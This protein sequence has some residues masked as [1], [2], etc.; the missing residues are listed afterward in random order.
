MIARFCASKGPSMKS[1]EKDF[2]RSTP[3]ATSKAGL[4]S[5]PQA[6]P[7]FP[8]ST[9]QIN[10][11]GEY[12]RDGY[13][14]SPADSHGSMPSDVGLEDERNYG[15]GYPAG[16]SDLG[17]SSES[18]SAS[19]SPEQNLLRHDNDLASRGFSSDG[20]FSPPIRQDSDAASEERRLGLGLDV[21]PGQQLEAAIDSLIGESKEEETRRN[22][23]REQE[24]DSE[25]D[26]EP[27]QAPISSPDLVEETSSTETHQPVFLTRY[28]TLD[29]PPEQTLLSRNDPPSPTRSFGSARSSGSGSSSGS[30]VTPSSQRNSWID[31]QQSFSTSRGRSNLPSNP[32]WWQAQTDSTELQRSISNDMSEHLEDVST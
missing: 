15:F 3:I 9:F 2:Q 24:Q 12:Q 4:H 23:D 13:G 8:P 14:V 22:Q 31:P 25:I 16:R 11:S 27:S 28:E 18:A 32:L 26:D 5:P 29:A 30:R 10:T 1:R 6:A 19:M 17:Y 20:S 7:D 21:F